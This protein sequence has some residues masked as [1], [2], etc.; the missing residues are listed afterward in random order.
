MRRKIVLS[1]VFLLAG[2]TTTVNASSNTLGDIRLTSP[3]ARLLAVAEQKRQS[4][5]LKTAA[6][7]KAEQAGW[8]VRGETDGLS[9]EL[10]AIERGRPVYNITNNI[11]AAISTA[12]NL[13][14][15]REPY[16]L[17]GSGLTAGIWD[18]GAVL[19]THQEFGSRVS[20]MDGA[21]SDWHS[22]HVGGTIGAVGLV[23][24][25]LGMAP[26][27]HIDSYDWNSDS[28]EMTSRAASYPQ[29]PDKMYL[30]NH[31]YGIAT[32]WLTGDYSGN[33]GPHW[34]GTWG[35]RE[36]D[37]FGQYSSQAV[38]WDSIC[39]LAPYYLPFKSAGNDRGDNAPSEGTTFYYYDGASW[40]AKSYDSS[41]DPYDDGWD[42]GGFDTI[43]HQGNAK[44]IMTVGAVGD[45]VYMGQRSL[46]NATMTSF[47]G[48]GPTD[49][50]RI[51]PDIVANGT[52]L[53]SSTNQSDTSYD[54][55]SGT[56]MS[57][58]D[59][60]GSAILLTQYYCGMFPGN[61]MRASTLKGLIIHTADD[62]GNAGP[63][64]S[65]GWGLMNAKAGADQIRDHKHYP[66]TNK[67]I[68]GALSASN[69]TDT[70]AFAWNGDTPIRATLCWTDPPA[71]ALQELDN[72]SPRL[73]ND[74][75]LAIIGP[76]GVTVYYPFVLDPA[77]PA[78]P[79]TTGDNTLD[80][81]EQVLIA[82]PNT[83]GIYTVQ[84]SYKGTLANEQQYY[85]VIISGQHHPPGP[86]GVISLDNDFYSCN[87]LLKLELRDSGLVAYGEQ[88]VLIT[89]GG[90][91]SETVTLYADPHRSGVFT[92]IISTSPDTA[93]AG[94]GILQVAH[95]QTITA[96][97]FDA[98]DG[99]GS[100]AVSN[101]TAL[102]DCHGPTIFNVQ[103]SEIT[104]SAATITF[105]TDEPATSS[106]IY[107]LVCGGPNT[108]VNTSTFATAHSFCLVGLSPQTTYYFQTIAWDVVGNETSD[109]NGGLCYQFTTA[110]APSGL[111]VPAD[112]PTI[113]QAIDAAFDGQTVFVA[114]GTYTGAGN[115]DIDFN[116]KTITVRSEN[117]P[118]NCIIN[119]Q[120]S[121][122]GPHRG[123]YFHSGEDP[124]SILYGFTITNGF[125]PTTDGY[126][127][128][129]AIYCRD[130][131]PT[132]SNCILRNN[133]A[134]KRWGMC[135][136]GG[137]IRCNACSP[138]VSNCT[139][140]D[141]DAEYGGG[142]HGTPTITNCT[143]TGNVATWGGAIQCEGIDMSNCIISNNRSYGYGGGIYCT[144]GSPLIANCLIIN[145]TAYDPGMG[146]A[147]GGGIEYSA[148]A[149]RP[150]SATF[151]NCT[152]VGNWAESTG[153]AIRSL[154][155]VTRVTNCIVRDNWPNQLNGNSFDVTYTNI[156]GGFSGE[157]NIDADPLFISANDYH[158]TFGSPCVDTGTNAPAGGLP[159]TDIEGTHRPLDGDADGNNVA[160]MGAYEYLLTLPLIELAQEE[161]WF[162]A[163]YG[164][165]NPHDQILSI[166]NTGAGILN[167]QV[168]E[169]CPWL[170]VAPLSGES[171]G[172]FDHVVLSVDIARL[173]LGQYSCML[174]ISAAG[175][176][177]SPR[178]VQVTLFIGN[179][180]SVPTEDYP[181]IQAGINAATNGDWVVLAEGAYRGEGNRDL[182]FGGKAIAVTSQNPDDPAVVAATVVDCQSSGRA[183]YFHS[184]ETAASVV[185]GLTITNGN[186]ELGG[187]IYCDGGSPTITNCLLTENHAVTAGGG[188]ENFSASPTVTNCIFTS[189]STD[190]WGGGMDNYSS[191]VTVRNCI[192][193][194]NSAWWGGG[195]DNA[196]SS[197]TITGC[198]FSG[199]SAVGWGGGIDNYYGVAPSVSNCIFWANSAPSGAEITGDCVV[200]YSDVWGGYSGG[201]NMEA[202]PCFVT[203]PLGD[204][205]LSQVA[206]GQAVDSPCVDAG[207]DTA[208]NLGLDSCTTRTDQ[209]VDQGIVDMGYHY[210]MP[211]PA[212]IDGDGDVDIGDYAILALQWLQPPGVPSADIV[213]PGGNGI[214]DTDDLG[215]LVE[216]WLWGK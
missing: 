142:I 18:A 136:R 120:G 77:N 86:A 31:S 60:S 210:P 157:G 49:D 189:N 128:G 117:G 177:N 104:S 201:A 36:A 215:L 214:V 167:W 178:T 185:A 45:A 88:D 108:T 149:G 44:N 213:P 92:G 106:L 153:G 30:S 172:E 101:S 119:C 65:F 73:I 57:A 125:A 64:Y 183:F 9:F 195:I 122:A 52:D 206:A 180:I 99:T 20:I 146:G 35:D 158:L 111:W 32:G 70:Y 56:S 162:S 163:I 37:G 115:R 134:D 188:M 68:E 113:Q 66:S 114:D 76:Y 150:H 161:F 181:T 13:I 143:F 198:T 61:A 74:L 75:D 156:H 139:I 130:S 129:G 121:L 124:N 53:Y 135:G 145:N 211:N 176:P 87:D 186:A 190:S 17:D 103:V 51:K 165:A 27:V 204:Y 187:G 15:D 141:N 155:R 80:N 123:F 82:T 89:T 59:A 39:Y 105:E 8:R 159:A 22:T 199:N 131:N 147:S 50:G 85:S 109:D 69:L 112:F 205:Y 196:D 170:D 21:D 90:S 174:T 171:T 67:I 26:N 1:I 94:D 118:T 71:D 5:E 197:L 58:P 10:M 81:V 12:A 102:A 138:I 42:N 11:N 63:D 40:Q 46:S 133:K 110:E 191:S 41:T 202:D 7:A 97:Y 126:P 93:N 137:A 25:A 168:S 200:S 179:V 164:R 62:L 173:P 207:S 78:N 2:G 24:L 144:D 23:P 84:V 79:A 100:P 203:G 160:D 175:A 72:S 216:Y 132:I 208:V 34:F 3:D 184:G 29:E 151:I 148:S 192:F 14:R 212:D 28:S 169:D 16:N 127:S 4:R 96:T 194:G 54:S 98:D 107:G 193:V 91:D 6:W 209:A 154:W 33:Y 43:P 19:S 55:S 38:T 83:P 152:I 116:G 140:E 47:S 166:R 48:W 182:D 95:G